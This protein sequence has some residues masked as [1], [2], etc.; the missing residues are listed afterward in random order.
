MFY[1]YNLR[2]KIVYFYYI[3]ELLLASPLSINNEFELEYCKFMK[4]KITIDNL[5][6]FPSM[7]KI[8]LKY[9]TILPSSAPVERLFSM[10]NQILTPRRNWL[11]DDCFENL[12]FLKQNSVKNK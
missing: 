2:R 10:A 12:L 5:A 1:L 9:N 8:F 7:Q 11:N 6:Q 3:Y 4:K